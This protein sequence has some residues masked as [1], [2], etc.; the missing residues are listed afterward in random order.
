MIE[1]LWPRNC[2]SRAMKKTFATSSADS[3]DSKTADCKK[4]A[5]RSIAETCRQERI[6]SRFKCALSAPAA[7][8]RPARCLLD[9]DP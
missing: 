6:C 8:R 9:F 2:I 3:A 7:G 4:S 1:S 5:Q